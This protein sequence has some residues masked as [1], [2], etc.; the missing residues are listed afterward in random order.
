[1]KN[2][3]VF[4][5]LEGN[6]KLI[7]DIIAEKTNSDILELKPKKKYHNSGFKKYFWGGR[8]VLFKEKPELSSYEINI[9]NYENIFI[10]TPIWVG[11]YAP[12]YNT[13]LNQERIYDKNIYLF[14]CHGGGGA[15][16]FYKNIK[17]SIPKNNFKGQID[18]ND[19][20][21]ENKEEVSEKVDTWLN[22]VYLNN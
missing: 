14:A 15:D 11:T 17:E 5:S 16:K 20:L 1:M 8:S 18:F 6:T 3:V 10:G 12:P 2:L 22:N 9:D 7:A 4:Y 21:K 13:F 19:P